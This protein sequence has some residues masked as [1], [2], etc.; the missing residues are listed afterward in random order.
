MLLW[1][2][3]IEYQSEKFIEKSLVKDTIYLETEYLILNRADEISHSILHEVSTQLYY[4][5]FFL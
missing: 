4:S 3:K 5:Q 1:R 2:P